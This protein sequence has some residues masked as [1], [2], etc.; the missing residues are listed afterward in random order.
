MLI[1]LHYAHSSRL[2]HFCF[3]SYIKEILQNNIYIY[4]NAM[5]KCTALMSFQE[6]GFFGYFMVQLD[7]I[8]L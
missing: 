7:S 8:Q 3:K 4:L 2:Y 6:G 5:S 1:I